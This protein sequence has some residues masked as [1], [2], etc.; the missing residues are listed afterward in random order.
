MKKFLPIIIVAIVVGVIGFFGGNAYGKSKAA[1]AMTAQSQS[2]GNF[3]GQAGM[4][5]RRGGAGGANGGFVTGKV[6]SK[7]SSSITLEIPNG[8]S[9]I[10]FFSTSTKITKSVEGSSADLK[11]GD[12]ISLM[13]SANQD[14]SIAA[15]SIQLR[16]DRAQSTSTQQ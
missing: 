2:R 8:G 16:P 15:Q 14:G 3:Q 12:Q 5:G 11:V 7:D 13:G 9:K 10:A 1:Q 6:I 4:N